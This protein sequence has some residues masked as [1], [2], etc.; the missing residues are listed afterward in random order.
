MN[1]IIVVV[2]VGGLAYLVYRILDNHRYVQQR[3]AE[4]AAFQKMIN[5]VSDV[6]AHCCDNI[7]KE[8]YLNIGYEDFL[9][10]ALTTHNDE[11]GVYQRFR[12]FIG[13]MKVRIHDMPV[14]ITEARRNFKDT[15]HSCWNASG[16]LSLHNA[17]PS[18]ERYISIRNSSSTR[19]NGDSYS[20]WIEDRVE[21]SLHTGLSDSC[22]SK[23]SEFENGEQVL[24]LIDVILS[25][26]YKHH[27]FSHGSDM[28]IRE[29]YGKIVKISAKVE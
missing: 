14:T 20:Q 12:A 22:V 28:F 1:Y 5:T 26:D 17:C 18:W 21:I 25:F 23:P 19:K 6:V 27:D 15:T 4:D 3:R 10:L 11:D 29:G 24:T 7:D 16:I 8:G 2:A 9:M 13:E